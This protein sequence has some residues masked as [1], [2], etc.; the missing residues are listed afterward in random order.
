MARSEGVRLATK[1][2][3]AAAAST[4]HTRGGNQQL[5]SARVAG[6]RAGRGVFGLPR[7][8]TGVLAMGASPGDW[9]VDVGHNISKCLS[10]PV[11]ERR[12]RR[13]PFYYRCLKP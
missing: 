10:S 1:G 9:G 8:E 6:R 5:A 3:A 12:V 13:K 11:P 4:P 7:V 2:T